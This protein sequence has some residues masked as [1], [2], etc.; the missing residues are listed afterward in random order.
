[1]LSLEWG[2]TNDETHNAVK[3]EFLSKRHEFTPL[4]CKSTKSLNTSEFEFFMKLI[5]EWASSEWNVY[6]PHA[7]E[8]DY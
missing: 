8:C 7:N 5:R 3:Y 4:T 6:I 2:Y 1:M